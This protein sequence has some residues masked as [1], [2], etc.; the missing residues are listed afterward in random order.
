MR[1]EPGLARIAERKRVQIEAARAAHPT[2]ATAARPTPRQPDGELRPIAPADAAR[3]AREAEAKRT[4][5][6]AEAARRVEAGAVK[7]AAMYAAAKPEPGSHPYLTGKGLGAIPGVRVNDTGQLIVPFYNDAGRIVN[8]QTID[9]DGTKKYLSGAQKIGAAFTVGNVKPT[10]AVILAEGLATAARI[11]QA[12][13]EGVVMT[14]DTSNLAPV[15]RIVRAKM[16]DRPI[17][18]AADNDHHL[19]ARPAPK[20]APNAGVAYATKAAEEVGNA[21]L[22]T[23]PALT[24][25]HKA[26][27]GTDWDDYAKAKGTAAVAASWRDDAAGAR[28]ETMRQRGEAIAPMVPAT[29]SQGETPRA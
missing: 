21:R 16:P 10:S 20:T 15:A 29:A 1:P 11:H 27:K 26:D 28:L 17:V 19:P 25:R 13:G 4:A 22:W 24:E 12:T 18:F 2:Q 3:F 6:S 14:A 9:P 5:A 23:P 7:A 8:V